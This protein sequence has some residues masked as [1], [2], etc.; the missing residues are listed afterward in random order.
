MA[1]LPSAFHHL[2][3]SSQGL[4]ATRPPSSTFP[5]TVLFLFEPKFPLLPEKTPPPPPI[6]SLQ[7][8]NL[9]SKRKR[10]ELKSLIKLL[11]LHHMGGSLSF[12]RNH[13]FRTC[14]NL[15]PGSGFL[16][17]SSS[18]SPPRSRSST[19]HKFFAAHQGVSLRS[20]R[21]CFALSAGGPRP[22]HNR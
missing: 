9:G 17:A 3:I 5:T 4:P 8:G 14:S 19:H 22:L 10:T 7:S 6:I 16:E 2:T 18:G 11:F 13:S 20:T 15:A 21:V 12:F 1:P